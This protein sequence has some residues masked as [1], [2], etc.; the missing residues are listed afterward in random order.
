M[1][2]PWLHCVLSR[3]SQVHIRLLQ[4]NVSLFEGRLGLHSK[5]THLTEDP[6]QSGPLFSEAVGITLGIIALRVQAVH[7]TL[8]PPGL[9]TKLSKLTLLRLIIGSYRTELLR[10]PLSGQQHLRPSCRPHEK[11]LQRENQ[12][13]NQTLVGR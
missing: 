12:A 9:G 13:I 10:L 8:E 5:Q 2:D 3:A 6:L 1:N 7:H 4:E 11:M